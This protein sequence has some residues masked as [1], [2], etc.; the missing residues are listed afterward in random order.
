[1]LFLKHTTSILASENMCFPLYLEYTAWYFIVSVL[2]IIYAS[3]QMSPSQEK[4]S[5]QLHPKQYDFFQIIIIIKAGS[6]DLPRQATKTIFKDIDIGEKDH[7]WVWILLH[8]NKRKS[9]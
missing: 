5:W 8:W 9:L 2:H 1:M 7:N 6:E 3:N 4:F